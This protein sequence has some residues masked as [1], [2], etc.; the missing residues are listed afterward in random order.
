MAS[1]TNEKGQIIYMDTEEDVG[2]ARSQGN[3]PVNEKHGVMQNIKE[4]VKDGVQTV[5]EGM[6]KLA[7]NITNNPE[8]DHLSPKVHVM[9]E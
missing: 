5:A 6:G 1:H 2:I 4:K 9:K 3:V 8:H 7:D